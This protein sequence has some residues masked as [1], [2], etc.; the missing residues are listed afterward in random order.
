MKN[1]V[2]EGCVMDEA[3]KQ[4]LSGPEGKPWK[5]TR[6]TLARRGQVPSPERSVQDVVRICLAA[7]Q[8]NDD[9]QLDH[10]A[11]VVLE[12]KSPTGPLAQG[13]LDPAGYGRFLRDTEYNSLLDFKTA[14]LVG[15]P[16]ELGDSVSVRQQVKVVEFSSGSNSVSAEKFFDFYLS[17]VSGSW[18][19]DVILM[20]K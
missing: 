14:E 4:Y 19:I 20:K 3:L 13:G 9:P 2:P 17:K 18:L 7:L 16:V 15:E 11:C 5:G 1:D 8:H 10:G 12:F 6:S